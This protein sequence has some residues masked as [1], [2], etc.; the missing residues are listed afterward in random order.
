MRRLKSRLFAKTWP[1]NKRINENE[2]TRL[3]EQQLVIPE[4]RRVNQIHFVGIGGAGMGGIAEVLHNQGYTISGSD[5][6]RG[7]VVNRLENLGVKVAIG[8]HADNITDA[9]VLVVSSAV[10]EDNAEVVAARELRIPIVQRAEMLGELMRFRHGIAVAGT[11]G[12]TTT[13][14]LIATIFAQAKLDPTFVIGGLLNSAGSNAR[15][16]T[17][18]YLIAEADESDASFLHLQPMLSVITNIEADHME[19]YGGD[20]ENLKSTYIDF[21]RN[22]P[23]YGVAVVCI[24]DDVVRDVTGR[25]GRKLITYG[26]SEDADYRLTNYR[27]QGHRCYFVIEGAADGPLNIQLNL[28]GLHNALNATAAVAVALDEGIEPQA[29]IA[30]LDQFEGIGRR[31]QQYGEFEL[32][33]P[34]K[35][36][37]QEQEQEPGNVMLVDDY[38]HHPSEVE[39]TIKAVRAGWPDRRLV[40]VYQ[41]HRYTRTRDLYEDFARVLSEVDVLLILEVYAAGEEPIAGADSRSLCRTIRQRGKLDPIF[42]EPSQSLYSLLADLL[43]DQDLLLTQGA[44]DIGGMVKVLAQSQLDKSKLLELGELV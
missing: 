30:A 15:L 7:L 38:G 32:Q 44:G 4:M 21:L 24:D 3:K 1:L 5:I 26:Q 18:R 43:S 14:S 2:Y 25:C 39:V 33:Q 36:R 23:F 31:F 9:S 27:Q 19:T 22:L 16:G 41:P 6:Q 34:N 37:E 17:S 12:K 8:H 11:H 42:V 29:I 20:F 28:P 13:T 40:M 10:G 35:E